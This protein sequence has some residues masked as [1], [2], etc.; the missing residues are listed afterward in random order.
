MQTIPALA[1]SVAVLGGIATW[2]FLTVG[3]ILIWAAF[4]AT[5]TM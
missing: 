4:M 2:M 5:W 3:G 1:L